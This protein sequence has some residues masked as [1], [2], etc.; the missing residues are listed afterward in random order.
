MSIALCTTGP[1]P[2][3]P[4]YRVVVNLRKRPC[5]VFLETA[6]TAQGGPLL[7][8]LAILNPGFSWIRFQDRQ[9]LGPA[10]KHG[11]AWI[12]MGY[13]KRAC[14]QT[15]CSDLQKGKPC[16]KKNELPPGKANM[17]FD[18]HSPQAKASASGKKNK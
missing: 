15:V 12:M 6:E 10:S 11:A 4:T 14:H 18:L 13:A 16:V 1:Q 17:M 3:E 5:L 2:Y 7:V 9:S 8:L